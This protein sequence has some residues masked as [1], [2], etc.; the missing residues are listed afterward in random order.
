MPILDLSPGDQT[1]TVRSDTS[2]LEVYRALPAGLYPPFPPVELP[3]G[4][5]GL[6]AR[7]GFAQTFFFAAEVLGVTFRSPSGRVIRAGGRT[8]KNVQGYDLTRL[9]VGSFGRLGE[10]LEVTL[11]LRPGPDLRHVV[12]PGSLA[13]LGHPTARFAWQDG[14]NVHLLHFGH[15]REVK[16]ALAALPQAQEVTEPLDLTSRFPN[17]MGVAE[18]ASLRDLRFGWVNGAGPPPVPPLFARL[19]DT[20]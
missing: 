5:G 4:I 13:A 8:V 16:R 12:A 6:V 1:I 11:R 15:A 3:G 10:A 18:S 20:L 9:F 17:G 14:D 19:A 2:L 7:G